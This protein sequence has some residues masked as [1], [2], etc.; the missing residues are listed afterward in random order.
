MA[1]DHPRAA[2]TP[3]RPSRQPNGDL[4]CSANAANK[5]VVDGCSFGGCDDATVDEM[6]CMQLRGRGCIHQPGVGGHKVEDTGGMF[7]LRPQ[8]RA[9]AIR[10]YRRLVEVGSA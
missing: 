2:C 7:R 5:Y 1:I 3:W 10:G 9:G 4:C 8:A 6:L